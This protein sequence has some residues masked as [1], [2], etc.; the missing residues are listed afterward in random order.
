MRKVGFYRDDDFMR[1]AL[2][3]AEEAFKKDEV[4]VGALIVL[5]NK[6]IAK[7][8]NQTELLCDA[9]AHCELLVITQAQ[10]FLKSKWLHRCSLYVTIEPCL[11]CGYAL[12]LT[13]VEKVIFAA[14]EPRSGAFG[15]V[16]DINKLGF[17]HKIKIKKGVLE[18]E[19]KGLLQD[20]FKKKRCRTY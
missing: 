4:P 16:I 13:R 2:K 7:A 18:A 14:P 3:E 6:V 8:H 9:T 1:K 20:F 5:D 19:A 12:L 11:M 17:N 15:S 10:S